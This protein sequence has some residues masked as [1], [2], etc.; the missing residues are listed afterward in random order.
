M[1]IFADIFDV[2]LRYFTTYTASKTLVDPLT[3]HEILEVKAGCFGFDSYKLP[4]TGKVNTKSKIAD[5][6]H[7]SLFL[8][9]KA[10]PTPVASSRFYFVKFKS[11]S[12]RNDLMSGLRGLLADVQIHEGI[13]V[14]TLY[15]PQKSA[16]PASNRGPG[17][18]MPNANSKE[19]QNQPHV[20]E[21][22]KESNGPEIL[23]PLSEVHK[24]LNRE[25]QNYDRL[26]LQ[27]LQGDPDL[28]EKEEELL[29]L[30][31][32]L[33]KVT[34]ESEEKD[35]VQANDSKLIMQLSKKL[36][37]LLMENEDLRDQNDRL[38]SRLVVVECE[39]MNMMK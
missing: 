16:N 30:H 7:A 32:K 22:S 10:S 17:R 6:K 31:G 12:A 21:E 26:L 5:G 18:R 2:A 35:R 13:S 27:M 28:R 23:V 14:S 9:L 25:R 29:S 19:A 1:V 39:K 33:D 24:A 4:S 36:E 37:M 8:T 15:S 11:R 20:P 38:N 3:L 34:A